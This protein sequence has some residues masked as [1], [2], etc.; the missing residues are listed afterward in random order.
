MAE[1]VTRAGFTREAVEEIS[2]L[3]YEPEWMR[4]RR[5]EAF[6]TYET[7]PLPA[8]NEEEWRRTDVSRLKLDGYVTFAPGGHGADA[9]PADLRPADDRSARAGL[10]VQHN[11][12]GAARELDDDVRAKGVIV[13][14]LDTAVRE[15][16][17]LVQRYFMTE[18]IPVT[19]NK[20]TALHAAFWSGGT[21]IYVPRNVEVELPVQSVLYADAP[22]L[23]IFGHTL[24][25]VEENAR[26]TY[27]EE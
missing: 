7:M 12:V 17:D 19:Y 14:D 21:F 9:L 22:G 24:I 15:H 2:G 3:K 27:V 1:T 13:A 4:M 8:R 6:D 11:S 25:V 20:F 26:L 10:L 5:L 18:A 23:G 16:P